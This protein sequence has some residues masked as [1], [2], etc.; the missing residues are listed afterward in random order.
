MRIGG[1]QI[2]LNAIHLMV[3]MELAVQDKYF[4]GFV[5]EIVKAID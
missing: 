3:R 1:D 4:N 2:E 5:R